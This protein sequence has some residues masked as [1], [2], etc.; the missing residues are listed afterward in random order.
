MVQATGPIY[1]DV[2]F[3]A[4]QACS[5]LHRT[6]AANATEFKKT[7]KHWAIVSDVETSLLL[8]VILHVVWANFAEKIDVLIS[9]KLGHFQV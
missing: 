1:G 2:A 9:V 6:T 4:V 7:I 5:S 8:A 3:L